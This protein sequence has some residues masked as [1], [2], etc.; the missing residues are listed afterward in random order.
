MLILSF[1]NIIITALEE[2]YRTRI[3]ST[4]LSST[5]LPPKIS[6]SSRPTQRKIW[7]DPS[8]DSVS[9]SKTNRPLL[10]WCSGQKHPIMSRCCRWRAGGAMLSRRH[11]SISCGLWLVHRMRGLAVPR[12]K[13]RRSRRRKSQ[14]SRFS[15]INRHLS[16]DTA[17]ISSYLLF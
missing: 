16:M 12:R 11:R 13:I 14:G 10:V 5:P 7:P 2:C 1:G 3:P 15:A 4:V 9:A 8:P 6:T 17:S